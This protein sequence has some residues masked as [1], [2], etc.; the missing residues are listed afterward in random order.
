[1][2]SSLF[3]VSV[4]S[5][6]WDKDQTKLTQDEY[7]FARIS[8]VGW[9]SADQSLDVALSL[10]PSLMPVGTSGPC[11]S[12]PGLNGSIFQRRSSNF[13][14]GMIRVDVDYKC[15][16][17]ASAQFPG[18][19]VDQ[20]SSLFDKTALRIAVSEAPLL[21]H[22]VAMKFPKSE[23]GLL[24]AYISG[25]I[26][27]GLDLI[28]ETGLSDPAG[29]EYVKQDVYGKWS[30]EVKF[31]PTQ[32][33]AEEITASPADYAKIIKAGITSYERSET[34]LSWTGTRKF[35]ASPSE[36]N[37]VGTIV[38]PNRAPKVNARQWFYTGIN[39]NQV[40][41][42]GGVGVDIYE[43]NKEYSLSGPGGAIKQLYK[44]GLLDINSV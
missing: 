33:T 42:G 38:I 28:A 44:G 24:S 40:T 11:G 4:G 23:I 8:C 3:N 39:Q 9:T 16:L 5:I 35:E 1:M 34:V 31:S 6:F 36:L 13:E 15:S 18:Q 21:T 41:T 29:K 19:T 20:A 7:Q 32:Y 26:R 12:A 2:G 37:S 14:D 17:V 43:F 22:P 10:V 25:Y 30:I 27:C